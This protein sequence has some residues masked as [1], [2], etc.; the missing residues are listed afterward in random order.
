[1]E[2]RK[3][4]DGMR[5]FGSTEADICRHM[6]GVGREAIRENVILAPWWQPA[7]MPELGSARYL[8]ESDFS[9]IRVWDIEFPS[10]GCTYIRTG[11]GA[12]C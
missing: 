5:R 4:I 11:I 8:S 6:L 3:L 9:A 7:S 2:Y 1:M 10:G 12:P